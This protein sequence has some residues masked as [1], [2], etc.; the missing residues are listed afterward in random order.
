[1][2]FEPDDTASRFCRVRDPR[3]SL[4]FNGA[5][6]FS[7]SVLCEK[8]R[9]YGDCVCFAQMRALRGSGTAFGS[10]WERFDVRSESDWARFEFRGQA[11]E[12]QFAYPSLDGVVLTVREAE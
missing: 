1:M 10:P 5:F 11:R 4:S 7:V 2:R 6:E 8:R 3:L 12:L 9:R